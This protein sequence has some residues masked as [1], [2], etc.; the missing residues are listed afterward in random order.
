MTTFHKSKATTLSKVQVQQ[1][2]NKVTPTKRGKSPCVHK[3]VYTGHTVDSVPCHNRFDPL[4]QIDS[5]ETD[6]QNESSIRVPVATNLNIAN[7]RRFPVDYWDDQLVD[8]L[9][10]GFPLDFD[11][12]L[13]LISVED[14]H[15][16]A[17]YY[18]E[19]VNHYL[20]EELD[21]G[22]ILGPFKK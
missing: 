10:F 21:Y 15:K 13:K 5:Q 4:N 6:E 7:W 20:Q 1:V 18:Q 17:K 19:H 12:S 9:E 2:H 16:S 14:N 8:L 3:S 11:R 22:T